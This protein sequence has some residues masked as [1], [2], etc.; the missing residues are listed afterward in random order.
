MKGDVPMDAILAASPSLSPSDPVAEANHRIANSLALLT[1]LVRMEASSARKKVTAFS[2]AEVCHLLDGVAARISTISQLHRI[3]SHKHV[4]GVVNMQP[5][6]KDVTDTMANALSFGE[7]QVRVVHTGQDCLVMMRHVQ[8]IVLILCEIF[9]NAVKYAHP[10]GVPLILVVDCEPSPDGELLLT[11]SDDGVGLPEGFIPERD[12]G[13]GFKV[14]YRLAQEMGSELRI[15]STHLG[16][17]FRLS[18]PA[19]AM[20]GAKLA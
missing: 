12:G 20:A 7:Q 18:L 17:S 5:H 19:G 10:A 3:L 16:L 1:G 14:M 8:P 13:M 2:S 9:I 11:V 4:D 15:L 6:L